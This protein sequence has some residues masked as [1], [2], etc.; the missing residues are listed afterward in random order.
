MWIEG[1]RERDGEGETVDDG[2][3]GRGSFNRLLI[4]NVSRRGQGNDRRMGETGVAG[5]QESPSPCAKE[6]GG[7]FYRTDDPTD[8]QPV[9]IPRRFAAPG[10]AQLSLNIFTQIN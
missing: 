4:G 3:C 10:N 7:Q 5:V 6:G 8:G 2:G 9:S 1:V